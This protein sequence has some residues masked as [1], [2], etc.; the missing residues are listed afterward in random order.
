MRRY[1]IYSAGF[2]ESTN[3]R[4]SWNPRYFVAARSFVDGWWRN[5][6][7][8]TI[9]RM[10]NRSRIST[11]IARVTGVTAMLVPPV[12][13]ATYATAQSPGQPQPQF[14]VASVKQNTSDIK[15]GAI[16][17]PPGG[18]FMAENMTLRA[19]VEFA[20]G[21]QPQQVS[22]GASWVDTDRFDIV[23]KGE[24]SVGGQSAPRKRD[25]ASDVKLML[26]S[27]LAER[28][29]LQVHTESRDLPIF[30]L[31]VARNDG[32][33]GPQIKTSQSDC[34]S[35]AAHAGATDCGIRMGKGP[36]TLV[37]SGVTMGQ[38]ASGLTPWAGRLV[39]DQTNLKGDYDLTLNW[40]PD[41]ISEGLSRKIA[42]G[43]LPPAD[44][45]GASIYTAVQEQLGL[46]LDSRRGPVD[47]IVIDRADHATPD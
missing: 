42:A 31:V 22:G 12:Q 18:R 33:L 44:P 3:N 27:L 8:P 24:P 2:V 5:K 39:V 45:N 34:S 43:G 28:F 19:L 11:L 6:N 23:A 36:G 17:T 37:A 4:P 35:P 9:L 14:E 29:K 7:S 13:S 46:K 26:R 41:Q 21:V 30:A 15:K 32:K 38:L 20:Y 10:P 1:I 16:Q 25:D 40:T 47:V